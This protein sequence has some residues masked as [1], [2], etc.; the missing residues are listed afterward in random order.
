MDFSLFGSEEQ[1]DAVLEQDDVREMVKDSYPLYL[2]HVKDGYFRDEEK[3]FDTVSL[4]EALSKVN[5]PNG[6]AEN[7]IENLHI[8]YVI[9][10]SSYNQD[11][12]KYW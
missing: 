2:S 3:A 10:E 9:S 1:I 7:I 11:S 12:E 4:V 5:D 8:E 6:L